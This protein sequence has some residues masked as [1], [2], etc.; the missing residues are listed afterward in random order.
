MEEGEMAV[1]QR[2]HYTRRIYYGTNLYVGVRDA[3]RRK[4][5][6]VQISKKWR[7]SSS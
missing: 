3:I 6:D 2:V 4:R 7:L 1:F 5:A